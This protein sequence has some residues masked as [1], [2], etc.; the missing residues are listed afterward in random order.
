MGDTRIV[1]SR[2][3]EA[4]QL[5]IDHKAGSESE[6][7]RIAQKGG[8]VTMAGIW[9]VGGLLAVSR[10][11]GNRALKEWVTADP[12]VQVFNYQASVK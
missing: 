10:A 4:K 5:S 7:T 2:N 12:H 1:L 6:K 9:R 3:G 11:F 8:Y